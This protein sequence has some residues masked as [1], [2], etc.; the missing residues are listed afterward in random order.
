LLSDLN[1]IC[2]AGDSVSREGVHEIRIAAARRGL[3]LDEPFKL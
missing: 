1:A 2:D 3:V